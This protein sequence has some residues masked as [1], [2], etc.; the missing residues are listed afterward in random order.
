MARARSGGHTAVVQTSNVNA[1]GSGTVTI[2]EE[3]V[4]PTGT[5]T[6]TVQGWKIQGTGYTYIKWLH[7]KDA[8]LPPP[9]AVTTGRGLDLVFAIDTRFSTSKT[10][11]EVRWVLIPAGVLA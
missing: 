4:S 8:P 11:I 3:K 5:R 2:F 10:A 1:A 7:Y 9:G 6:F